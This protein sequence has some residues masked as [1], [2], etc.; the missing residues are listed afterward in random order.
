M[1][2]GR[3]WEGSEGSGRRCPHRHGGE[4]LGQGDVDVA[5]PF[6]GR[7]GDPNLQGAYTQRGEGMH[8]GCMKRTSSILAVSLAAVLLPTVLPAR[9]QS[10][11]TPGSVANT[12][13]ATRGT[14]SVNG[15]A[16]VLV[17]PDQV[18]L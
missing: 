10:L 11:V 13:P 5:T 3:L 15:T 2:I 8:T 14:I 16:Q 1:E 12:N 17:V 6:T 7:R 18:E 4:A 9:A